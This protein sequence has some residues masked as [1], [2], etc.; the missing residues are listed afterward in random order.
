[1]EVI[2]EILCTQTS[3][4][5]IIE[6]EERAFRPVWKILFFGLY[7]VKYDSNSVFVVAS[8]NSLV[9]VGC[10]SDDDAILC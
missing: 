3:A 2:S 8:H 9:S 6:S 10:V 4:M 7:E 5:A 1:M